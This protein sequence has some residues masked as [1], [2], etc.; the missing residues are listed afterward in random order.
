MPVKSLWELASAACIKHIR[1]LDGVGDYL[2]YESVRHILFKVDNAQQL[3]RIEENSPHLEGQ[4][5]EI[6]LKLIERDFPL[7]YRNR[8]YKPQNPAKWYRVWEKYKRDHDAAIEE[9]AMKLKS[10]FAGLKEDK[11]KNTSRIVEGRLLPTKGRIKT[12]SRRG[13]SARPDMSR[14]VFSSG[15][16][17]KTLNGA[18][19]MRK[20][21]REVKEIASIHGKLS[22]PVETSVNKSR[23]LAQVQRAPPS[24]VNEHRIAAQPTREPSRKAAAPKVSSAV[25]EHEERATFISDSEEDEQDSYE[26]DEELF[27][28]PAREPNPRHSKAPTFSPSKPIIRNQAPTK[29]FSS[30][31]D[32]PRLISGSG[33]MAQKFGNPRIIK[34]STPSAPST[35]RPASSST[36]TI[37]KST[38]IAESSPSNRYKTDTR[39][40]SRSRSPPRRAMSPLAPEAESSAASPAPPPRKRK[41]TGIFMRPKKRVT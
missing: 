14:L 21:R 27:D 39:S 36:S 3:R 5:G 8:A 18:G 2:P 25:K 30:Q 6:W 31:S 26:D 22:R 28:E 16:K 33:R 13:G 23:S 1:Q 29:A 10:A 7:E 11:E 15:S 40:R 19:V 34:K 9:S 37:H 12:S 41:A 24:M 35:A 32:A 17:T 4:T 38:I 20:V